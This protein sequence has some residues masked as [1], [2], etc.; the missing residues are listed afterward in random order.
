[1]AMIPY[2]R[3]VKSIV[4]GYD[5]E[6]SD[7][8]VVSGIVNGWNILFKDNYSPWKKVETFAGSIA[9]LFGFPLKNIMRDVRGMYNTVNTL[10]SDNE[11]TASG[12]KYAAIEGITGDSKKTQIKNKLMS[13]LDGSDFENISGCT[14]ELIDYNMNSGKSEKDARTAVKTQVTTEL[15]PRY[16]ESYRNKDN[17][18]MLRIRKAMKATGLYDDVVKTT[19]DWIKKSNQ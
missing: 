10:I 13:S 4:E 3:D 19:Q 18:E 16:I 6:R 1:M 9:N 7:M 17:D 5:V 2:L 14:K 11:T 12:I 15:K 8:S